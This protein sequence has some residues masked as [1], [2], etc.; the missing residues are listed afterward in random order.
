MKGRNPR[1]SGLRIMQANVQRG[2][3]EHKA[4]LQTALSRRAEIVLIQG[5][6]TL[7]P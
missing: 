3:T 5:P 6:A 4:A 2:P 7:T 1:A